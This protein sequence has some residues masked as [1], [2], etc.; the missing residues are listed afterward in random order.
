VSL[1]DCA[2]GSGPLTQPSQNLTHRVGLGLDF[3]NSTLSQV[4]EIEFGAPVGAPVGW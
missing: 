3:S 1:L 2:L 4:L